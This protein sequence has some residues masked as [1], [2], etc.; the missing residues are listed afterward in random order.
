MEPFLMDDILRGTTTVKRWQA[1]PTHENQ[2][3]A[4]HM[5]GVCLLALEFFDLIQQWG[6]D[7]AGRPPSPPT[8]AGEVARYALMHDVHEIYTGDIPSVADVKFSQSRIEE[9]QEKSGYST[10]P[11]HPEASPFVKTLVK[12]ADLTEACHFLIREG[13]GK[14]KKYIVSCLEEDIAEALNKARAEF[15]DSLYAWDKIE[16]YIKI[17]LGRAE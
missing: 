5:Y 6:T 4:G 15:T 8:S 3:I 2:S 17:L 9:I 12:L 14:R 11:K 7:Y 1:V 16:T 10:L 13:R